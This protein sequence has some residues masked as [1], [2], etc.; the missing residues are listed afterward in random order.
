MNLKDRIESSENESTSGESNPNMIEKYENQLMEKEEKIQMLSS[1]VS[2]LKSELQKRSEEIAK[3]NEHIGMMNSA[4]LI[5]K[6]NELLQKEVEDTIAACRTRI[7]DIK[8]ECEYKERKA[9]DIV[10]KYESLI[11]EA[12][13]K[14]KELIQLTQ[15]ISREIRIEVDNVVH[16]IVKVE[17]NKY[18]DMKNRLKVKILL[19]AIYGVLVTGLFFF[20]LFN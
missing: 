6:E 7:S 10:S 14:K 3:L 16:G 1:E 11:S 9:S 18:E 4:D 19:S 20:A 5:L 17:R 12:E 15:N 13:N 2:K 8:R